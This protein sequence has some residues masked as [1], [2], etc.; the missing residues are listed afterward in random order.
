MNKQDLLDLQVEIEDA[1]KEKARLEGSNTTLLAQLNND[2][3]CNTIKKAEALLETKKTEKA[4]L[5]VQLEEG[6]EKL[7]IAMKGEVEDED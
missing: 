3:G 2:W 1:K 5:S 4:S 6:I 7:E